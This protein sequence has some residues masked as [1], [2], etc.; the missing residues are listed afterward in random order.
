MPREG[1]GAAVLGREGGG[2][3]SQGEHLRM[4]C[5]SALLTLHLDLVKEAVP[6]SGILCPTP[7]TSLLSAHSPLQAPLATL[8]LLLRNHLGAART[9]DI[10]SPTPL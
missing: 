7:R 8:A 1:S 9:P 3:R 4:V 10:S 5:V 2:G 6:P